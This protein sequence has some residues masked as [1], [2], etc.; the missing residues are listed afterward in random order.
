[1]GTL[2]VINASLGQVQRIK[3]NGRTYLVADAT[4]IVPGVLHG[5][6][7]SLYYPP[8]EV[9]SNPAKWDHIP[10]M[11]NHPYDPVTN[12][13]L[14]ANDDGVWER[15][16][17]GEIRNTVYKGKLKT[18][19]WFD[20]NL[21]K[22][23]SPK[24]YQNLINNRP[25]ELST[26]L[27]TDNLTAPPNSRDPESGRSYDYIATNYRPDHLAVL[28]NQTGACSIQDG[29]GILV[30]SKRS[31]NKKVLTSNQQY[32]VV[33]MVENNVELLKQ[34]NLTKLLD[35]FNASQGRHP[36][37][38]KFQ[39]RPDTQA[40]KGHTQ[41]G[42][43]PA[44]DE[45]HEDDADAEL[46]GPKNDKA[47]TE[48]HP[49]GDDGRDMVR[50]DVNPPI[51][52]VDVNWPYKKQDEDEEDGIAER[53]TPDS[54][55]VDD[56]PGTKELDKK[57]AGRKKVDQPA[58]G[59]RLTKTPATLNWDRW[60]VYNAK[61]TQGKRDKTSP[62]DF[63][64]P[65]QSFPI[66]DQ[67][68]VKDAFD[69][70]GHA[71]NP[72]AVGDKVKTIAKR[73]GLTPPSGDSSTEN[74]E[75]S[76]E[77][78]ID[79][80]NKQ[81]GKKVNNLYNYGSNPETTSMYGPS[82]HD[83]SMQAAHAS[84]DTGHG[85]AMG[86]ATQAVAA[87]GNDNPADAVGFH[88]AAQKEHQKQA[89]NCMTK[90]DAN[91]AQK[92]TF[93]A[94]CHGAACIHH[95][96]ENKGMSK[97]TNSDPG[98][99]D[100]PEERKAVMAHITAGEDSNKA[101]EASS[102]AK[103]SGGHAK[104]AEAHRTAAK[105]M[106]KAGNTKVAKAHS[107]AAKFH[108]SKSGTNNSEREDMKIPT[109]EQAKNMLLRN[110]SCDEQRAAVNALSPS[111]AIELILNAKVDSSNADT[112]GPDDTE[113]A[114][115]EEED[116]ESEHDPDMFEEKT[117]KGAKVKGDKKIVGNMQ[118]WL[119]SAPPQ[120]TEI[121]N[122]ALRIHINEKKNLATR[123]TN[124]IANPEQRTRM[125]KS[126]MSDKYTMNSLKDLVACM[127]TFNRQQSTDMDEGLLPMFLGSNAGDA[128]NNSD[129]STVKAEED[130]LPLPTM[131]YGE[132]VK[133]QRTGGKKT[134]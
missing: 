80:I 111:K 82:A 116:K 69:L 12:A 17:L 38:G 124:N 18:K 67:S 29:C 36:K 117:K 93:A 127:P 99:A 23:K 37:T 50:G 21:T 60:T 62:K 73:K 101:A 19:A 95:A 112:D 71:D 49:D 123:L 68:D 113:Q 58:D 87:L 90:N 125:L 122:N 98:W 51:R 30:N 85:P 120:A 97:V 118:E 132:I 8:S 70:R 105:S 83:T 20:E 107:A 6:K 102:S 78:D 40:K 63:A 42:Y 34:Q 4:M 57:L 45:L 128:V 110:C 88:K 26:G 14:S 79:K 64:G 65:N 126:F 109:G 94:N 54:H 133:E 47:K 2:V 130:S 106:A 81:K 41:T 134:G 46:V 92:H 5:S 66:K 31:T 24:I 43:E 91:G 104:A 119:A 52:A 86:Q 77:E 10:L 103:S 7:G 114:G 11:E 27:F 28:P 55:Q 74:W 9:K 59:K 48:K 89:L 84:L 61:W 53:E 25:L 75:V 131:N 16:G 3:E 22:S 72:E 32:K 15:Q 108:E 56:G 1:M 76:E 129:T 44:S 100:N 96:A 39:E 121:W 35:V 33:N 13:P 115:G